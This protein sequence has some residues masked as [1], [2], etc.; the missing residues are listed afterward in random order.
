MSGKLELNLRVTNQIINPCLEETQIRKKA[1][2]L[3]LGEKIDIEGAK[4]LYNTIFTEL[5]ENITS[6]LR[7]QE[8]V[9]IYKYVALCSP[10]ATF[11]PNIRERLQ[12]QI[13]K[14]Y[15]IDV[16]DLSSTPNDKQNSLLGRVWS[17]L[18]Y[19]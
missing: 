17:I 15:N 13:L 6:F 12:A 1:S 16:S 18:G 11:A 19:S 14:T 9:D 5:L 2:S 7:S 10:K 8:A 4:K 3:G